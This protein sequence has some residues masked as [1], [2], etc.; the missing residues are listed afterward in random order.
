MF[1]HEKITAEG[2]ANE[3]V[4]WVDAQ[5][6]SGGKSQHLVFV[7]DEMGTFIGDSNERIGELNSLAEMI[8]NKG[9]GKVWIVVTSQQDLEKVVDRTNFQPTLVRRLNARFELKPHLISDEINKVVS[10]RIL[11]KRPAEEGAL[12]SIYA[13]HEGHIAHLA[14][15]KANRRLA[16]VTERSFIDALSVPSA[17]DS[18]RSGHFRGAFG[19]PHIGWRSLDDR[20]RDG[21]APRPSGQAARRRRQLRPGLRR[22]RERPLSQVGRFGR[23]LNLR[24]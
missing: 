2:I 12:K 6:L 4:S 5:S 20:G 14:D 17:S 18:P 15:V 16:S 10:E 8:G 19:L 1:R 21:G 23:A 13:K 22:G 11:K 9:K 24:V 7:I 3:L